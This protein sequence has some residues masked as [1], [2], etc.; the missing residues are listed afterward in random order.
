MEVQSLVGSDTG[1]AR[2]LLETL[3]IGFDAVGRILESMVCA[4][5]LYKSCF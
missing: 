2:Y 4:D 5:K 3:M 1:V